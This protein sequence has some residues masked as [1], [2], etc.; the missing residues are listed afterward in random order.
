MSKDKLSKAQTGKSVSEPN[1]LSEK[2]LQES[3]GGYS[4]NVDV[5]PLPIN[6]ATPYFN[7]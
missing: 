5:T 6:E 2:G 4:N 1:L 3:F 7:T